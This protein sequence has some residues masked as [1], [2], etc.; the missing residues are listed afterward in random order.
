MTWHELTFTASHVLTASDMNRVQA[1]FTALG[2]GAAGAPPIA[3]NSLT[4]SGVASV[5]TLN[6]SSEALVG[7][8]TLQFKDERGVANGYASLDAAATVP[9]SQGGVPTGALMPY[10]GTSAPPGWLLCDGTTL[11]KSGSGADHE[12]AAYE[13]LFDMLKAMAPNAGTESF[14]GG[15]TVQLPDLRGRTPIGLDTLGGSDAGR[16]TGASVPNR[17]SDDWDETLGGTAGEDLHTLTAAEMPSHSHPPPGGVSRF[18]GHN[19]GAANTAGGGTRTINQHFGATGAAGG[20]GAHNTLPP[21]LA[22]A[23]IVKT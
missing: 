19:F 16:V 4:V 13:P 5:A 9:S 22:L 20:G 23:W 18:W 7:G 15:D 14:D 21:A 8:G 10:A 17:S 11:G 3:V 6:V 2:A 1:N 12:G